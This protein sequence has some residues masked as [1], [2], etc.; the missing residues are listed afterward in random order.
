MR[1]VSLLIIAYL[2]GYLQ[3]LG[4]LYRG[5]SMPMRS[6]PFLQMSSRTIILVG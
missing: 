6:P 5:M 3:L 1:V 2:M 4:L